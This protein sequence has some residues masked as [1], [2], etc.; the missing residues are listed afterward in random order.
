MRMPEG[1][2]ANIRLDFLLALKDE[3]S[4]AATPP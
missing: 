3:D 2:Q 1:A 4:E